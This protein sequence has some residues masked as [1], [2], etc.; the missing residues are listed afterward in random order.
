MSSCDYTNNFK[1]V[2]LMTWGLMKRVTKY[3]NFCN[4]SVANTVARFTNVDIFIRDSLRT[5]R[6]ANEQ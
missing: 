1:R 3:L 5:K 6:H 4:T 2:L